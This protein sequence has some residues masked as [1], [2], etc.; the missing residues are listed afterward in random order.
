MSNSTMRFFLLMG[1]IGQLRYLAIGVGLFV[2]KYLLDTT[3]AYA[4][5]RTWS[6]LSYLLW[7]NR[8]S[9]TVASLPPADREFGVVMLA[10]A[11]P[12]IWIGLM[13]T[14]QRLRDARL[15][16]YLAVLFFV[17]LV[18]LLLIFSLCLAPSRPP[19]IMPV[20]GTALAK[21]ARKV[22]HKVA[23]E[24]GVLAFILAVLI[25]TGVTLGSVYLAVNLLQ[26]YGFG[27][28]VAAPFVQG[29]LAAI[30]YGLPTQRTMGQCIIVGYVSLLLTA[31][32]I[33][34]IAMEGIICIVMAAPIAMVLTGAGIALGYAMQSRPWVGDATPSMM[35]GLAVVLPTLIAAESLNRP[36]LKLREDR[37]E[38]IVDA[39][40]E[41]VWE[42]V[43]AFPPLEEPD[44]LLFQSGIAYPQRA[45][46]HGQGVGAVRHCVFSTGP[47]VEPIDVWDQPH[48]LAFHVTDQPEPMRE[49]SPF[50]IHPPH[51]DNFL[52]SRRGEFLLEE[53]PDG[54]TRLSGTT[55]YTNRMWPA[56][57]WGFW[58]DAIIHKIH[59]RVLNHV[60]DVAETN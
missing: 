56:N 34:C 19:V 2:V 45:E 1:T 32:V 10:V 59:Q 39:S 13:L 18:N 12:F 9:V 14:I 47:F 4:F 21:R 5:G 51:L 49:L 46:I 20:T 30:L 27:A 57:Y 31:I 23:G 42:T 35:L 16:L 48:Q 24:S 33:F 41:K 40:P 8:E 54:R 36:E 22:H 58:S 29:W 60:R 38:V 6:P 25:S 17:P 37:T 43:I 50:D 55:W 44:D 11:L 26:T 52:V 28:F 7:P 3:V 15:P 53:L